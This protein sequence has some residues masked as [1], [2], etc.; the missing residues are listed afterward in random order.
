MDGYPVDGESM[1]EIIHDIRE[2]RRPLY[3]RSVD[4][5]MQEAN[6]DYLN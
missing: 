5:D 6:Q 4:N 2:R 3:L 1:E